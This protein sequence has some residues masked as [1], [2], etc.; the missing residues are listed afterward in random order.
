MKASSD[1]C[2]SYG[3]NTLHKQ[4]KI[5]ARPKYN[6]F[7]GDIRNYDP[8][9]ATQMTTADPAANRSYSLP[10]TPIAICAGSLLIICLLRSP[11][12]T[13]QAILFG[14]V[15]FCTFLPFLANWVVLIPIVL[16]M[17]VQSRIEVVLGLSMLSWIVQLD[18][19]FA[20][21]RVRRQCFHPWRYNQST[22]HCSPATNSSS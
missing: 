1:H 11:N 3:R 18:W 5:F 6:H 12:M 9:Y 7:A 19:T 13:L 16:P 14:Q 4:R 15:L 8:N 10:L 22:E 20:W 17:K 21:E 2:R